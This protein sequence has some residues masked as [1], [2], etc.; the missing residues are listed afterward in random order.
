MRRKETR[1]DFVSTKTAKEARKQRM[2]YR[3]CENHFRRNSVAINVNFKFFERVLTKKA[4][5]A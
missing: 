4:S 2:K 3:K 5:T 1:F